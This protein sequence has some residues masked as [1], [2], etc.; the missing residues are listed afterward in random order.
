ML[1]IE[2]IMIDEEKDGGMRGAFFVQILGVD[3]KGY[4]EVEKFWAVT[5]EQRKQ[6]QALMQSI[7]KIH[8]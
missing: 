3:N 4:P 8:Q 5:P 7:S 1:F 2:K 6:L